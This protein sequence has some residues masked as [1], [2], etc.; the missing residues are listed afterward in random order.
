MGRIDDALRQ[1]GKQTAAAHTAEGSLLNA[2]DDAPDVGEPAKPTT[3]VPARRQIIVS[4]KSP[5]LEAARLVMHDD[6]EPVVVEQYRRLAA[7]LHHAQVERGVKSVILASAQAAEGK[8]LTAVNLA[9]TLSGASYSG[10][11]C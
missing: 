3:A 1:A 7:I 9:L 10:A 4:E 6:T 5:F 8:T 11:S 2:F